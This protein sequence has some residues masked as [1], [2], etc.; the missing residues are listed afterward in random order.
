[1]LSVD[2]LDRLYHSIIYRHKGTLFTLHLLQLASHNGPLAFGID[3]G[4]MNRIKSYAGSN[5]YAD[6]TQGIDPE[7]AFFQTVS[8]PFNPTMKAILALLL[9]GRSI[10]GV[11]Y[12]LKRADYLLVAGVFASFPIFCVGFFLL[13][14]LLGSPM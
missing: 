4:V 10:L 6:D 2:R 1:M 9:L 11:G 14:S 7:A 3:T 13:L 5:E 8:K 12:A